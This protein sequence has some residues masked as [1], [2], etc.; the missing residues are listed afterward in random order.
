M[1]CAARVTSKRKRAV[2]ERRE[3]R[4]V[5]GEARRHRAVEHVDAERD[6]VQEVVGLA[7]AEQVLGGVR[8]QH[9]NGHRQ[10]AVHLRLVAAE[11]PADREPVDGRAR[12]RLGGLAAQV[13][14]HAALDDPEHGLA[15][16][17]VRRACQARQRPSQRWVRSVE[18]AV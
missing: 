16:R 17:P 13:L 5:A 12:D 2:R 15:R 3:G 4:A 1:A 9:R 7:D 18:R 8:G 10:H 6:P 14:V 11:G